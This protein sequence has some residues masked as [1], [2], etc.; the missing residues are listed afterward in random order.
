M[1]QS[2]YFTN[3]SKFRV[4]CIIS[5]FQLITP[6]DSPYNILWSQDGLAEVN[7][8]SDGHTAVIYWYSFFI[9]S[10]YYVAVPYTIIFFRYLHLFTNKPSAYANFIFR[11]LAKMIQ[12][13]YNEF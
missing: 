6:Y 5:I 2:Y 7:S 10:N 1:N 12:K 11:F 8:Y 3:D 4:A 9:G 13:N